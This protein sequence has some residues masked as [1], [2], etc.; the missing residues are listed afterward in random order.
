MHASRSAFKR[1]FPDAFSISN[2]AYKMHM[3]YSHSRMTL[4]KEKVSRDVR[5]L[6]IVLAAASFFPKLMLSYTID[7]IIFKQLKSP[8]FDSVPHI[9][10]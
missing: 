10:L 7:Y 9:V 6:Q 5:D 4:I 8:V 1:Y 3:V 2:R